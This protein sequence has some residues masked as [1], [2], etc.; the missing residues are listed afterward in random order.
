M[1]AE[2]RN[3][4]AKVYGQVRRAVARGEISDNQPCCVCGTPQDRS[5]KS[6]LVTLHHPDYN[7][8][9]FVVPLCRGCHWDVHAGSIA[10]PGRDTVPDDVGSCPSHGGRGKVPLRRR[11]LAGY[12]AAYIAADPSRTLTTLAARVGL[13]VR[14]IS[15]WTGGRGR[16][17]FNT[18]IWRRFEFELGMTPAERRALI[19]AFGCPRCWKTLYRRHAAWHCVRCGKLS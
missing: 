19:E 12:I 14:Q 1:T 11:L 8:P 16:P 4:R 5:G 6:L 9:L 15:D 3:Q 2:L 7:R 18:A 17:D 13:R 10:D